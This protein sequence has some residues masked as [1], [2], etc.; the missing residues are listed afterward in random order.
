MSASPVTLRTSYVKTLSAVE[1]R[2]EKSNQHEFNG[3][4]GL[5]KMFGLAAFTRDAIF[6]VQGENIQ[7]R[8]GITWYDARESHPTR[9]EHRLYFQTNPVMNQ[10]NEG[11]HMVIGIDG[12]NH[13][14]CI[15]MKKKTHA[16]LKPAPKWQ[17]LS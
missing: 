9:S 14:H 15:L 12:N 11:D 5:K 1:V 10:A 13:I 4:Q 2:P 8:S 3:V 7:C 6:S 16:N 17:S